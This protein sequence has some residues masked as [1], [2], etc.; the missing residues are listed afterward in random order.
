MRNMEATGVM[1]LLSALV[2]VINESLD[3]GMWNFVWR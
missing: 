3:P 1:Y 2:A